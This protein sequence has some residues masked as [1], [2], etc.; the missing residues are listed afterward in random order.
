[1]RKTLLASATL[2]GLAFMPAA[3]AQTP[4]PDPSAPVAASPDAGTMAP[5]PAANDQPQADQAPATGEK[6]APKHHRHVM[7]VKPADTDETKFAHEPGTGESGPAS[8]KASNTDAANTHSDIA[9]HFPSPKGGENA[10]PWGYLHDADHAL[11]M[12]HTGEAQQALEMAE[13]RLLDRSTPVD[14]ASQP[15]QGPVVAQVTQ[16]RNALGHGDIAGARSAIQMALSHD[17]KAPDGGMASP[18]GAPQGNSGVK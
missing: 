5:P 17:P 10:G 12:K 14:Q 7:K 6:R 1:M 13:T 9:P 2:F 11:A 4:A 16:A 8:M 15:D 3:F 18:M